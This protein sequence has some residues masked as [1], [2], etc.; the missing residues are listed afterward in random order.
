M[1]LPVYNFLGYKTVNIDYKNNGEDSNNFVAIS[2]SGKMSEN[3][4]YLLDINVSADFIKDNVSKFC[5]ESAFKINDMEWFNKLTEQQ[6]Q[7]VFF[8]I[9]FPFIREKLFAITSDVRQGLFIPTL[10]LKT[11]DVSKGIKLN[12]VK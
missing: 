5:F 11:M 3:D 6:K 2:C 7:S 4:M 12:R 8:S 9:V 1:S 10:D